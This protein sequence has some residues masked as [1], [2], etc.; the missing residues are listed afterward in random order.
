MSEARQS[1]QSQAGT[2]NLSV[3]FAITANDSRGFDELLVKRRD[4]VYN[5]V[6]KALNDQGRRL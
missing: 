2:K 1:N 3:N 4:L 5:M 6:Q